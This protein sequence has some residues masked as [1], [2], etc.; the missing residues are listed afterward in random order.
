MDVSQV[1]IWKE[2]PNPY[3]AQWGPSVTFQVPDPW[4]SSMTS[5]AIC[6]SFQQDTNGIT[7]SFHDIIKYTTIYSI[8]FMMLQK[9]NGWWS[10]A[11]FP[12]LFHLLS[13][14]RNIAWCLCH[15]FDTK[16]PRQPCG[17]WCRIASDYPSP[18]RQ[19]HSAYSPRTSWFD[20]HI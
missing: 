17:C 5:G 14:H 8:M 12:N 2:T 19:R 10:L 6:Y 18:V 7:P 11:T 13:D 16:T 3:R 15:R 4:R 9:S 20:P 1:L